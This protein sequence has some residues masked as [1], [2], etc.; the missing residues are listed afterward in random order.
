MPA[1]QPDYGAIQSSWI[2]A[3]QARRDFFTVKAMLEAAERNAKEARS[4]YDAQRPTFKLA[5]AQLLVDLDRMDERLAYYREILDGDPSG[6]PFVF[7]A[8]A[9][10]REVAAGY[11]DVAPEGALDTLRTMK[12]APMRGDLSASVGLLWVTTEGVKGWEQSVWDSWLLAMTA[13]PVAEILSDAGVDADAQVILTEV[14]G[15]TRA[16]RQRSL[17]EGAAT[18]A[19]LVGAG[20]GIVAA[21]RAWRG[22]K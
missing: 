6:Y 3:Y 12:L 14:T 20:I 16:E 11:T 8:L 21:V 22:G 5:N 13:G 17:L 7:A 9:Y 10:G 4:V 18:V 2:R 19:G 1:R 15:K